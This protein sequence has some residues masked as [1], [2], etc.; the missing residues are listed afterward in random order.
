MSNDE[1]DSEED[2]DCFSN[3]SGSDLSSPEDRF[4]RFEDQKLEDDNNGGKFKIENEKSFKKVM[5][6]LLHSVKCMHELGIIHRDLKLDNV[7]I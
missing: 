4:Q 7:M 1:Y 3:P 5:R 6:Q 2:E